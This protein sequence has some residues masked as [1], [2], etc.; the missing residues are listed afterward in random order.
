MNIGAT[1]A[2]GAHATSLGS[3]ATTYSPYM[4]NAA[5]ASAVAAANGPAGGIDPARTRALAAG[6]AP[7]TAQEQAWV[8]QVEGVMRGVVNLLQQYVAEGARQ[9]ALGRDI[10]G[11]PLQMRE[12]NAFEQRVLELINVERARA[13]L[14]GL[15]YDRR[16][17]AAAEGH[18]GRQAMTGIMAH[19]G[20]GDGDPGMRI[21]YT[22]F[23]RAWGENVATGQLNPEQVVAEWMASPGHRRN[24]LDPN[25]NL[26]GVS[27][28]VGAGGRTFWTQEFG[29]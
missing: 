19:E 2:T 17:D 26:L 12:D 15:S 10:N 18:N 6:A 29:A 9:A 5:P 22:G 13:G 14:G 8:N 27:F 21:R 1:T 23:D 11:Q 4:A 3:G 25:F 24:I 7:A 16:L 28:E 20:I